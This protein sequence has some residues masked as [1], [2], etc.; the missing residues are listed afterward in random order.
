MTIISRI[1]EN[2]TAY[3]VWQAPFAEKKLMPLIQNNDLG[4]ARRVL[5]VG[6]GPGTNTRHFFHADYVGVD[7]NCD[8]IE[9]ARRRYGRKFVAADICSYV[10]P[11]G[12]GF[13]F[14]LVNSFL[15]HVDDGNSSR[16]LTKLNAL[17]TPGG[18]IHILDLVMP[19]DPGIARILARWDRG[20]FPRP[21]GE[22]RNIFI[23]NF[24][25]IVVEPY[26][27]T[28]FGIT[29][30]SMVYFKGKSRS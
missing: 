3:R 18:H 5:D 19:E 30:W 15:H 7:A 4:Q 26:P 9:Y 12:L 20:A 22:W 1:M 10:P 21:L 16:I 24:E 27:L 28:A 17:L 29:L 23:Q 14:I 2:V 13:D 6:C 8:Y 25:P 11:L